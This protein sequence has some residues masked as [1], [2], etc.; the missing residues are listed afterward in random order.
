[1]Q[2]LSCSASLMWFNSLVQEQA[3]LSSLLQIWTGH[4]LELCPVI[5]TLG[6]ENHGS[7]LV[8]SFSMQSLIW[9][10]PCYLFTD[11]LWWFDMISVKSSLCVRDSTA[12]CHRR[13]LPKV[14]S[15]K[16]SPHSWYGNIKIWSHTS[17]GN[18]SK[19]MWE[20]HGLRNQLQL[21]YGSVSL[22]ILFCLPHLLRNSTFDY[23]RV[24]CQGTQTQSFSDSIL[25]CMYF[26]SLWL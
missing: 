17:I 5:I 25:Q 22:D 24:Y 6:M 23:F 14:T 2:R 13:C 11:F 20:T 7:Q 26:I 12:L 10:C 21:L 1:M 16:D 4:D 18:N 15:L 19:V 9:M 8:I 3:L